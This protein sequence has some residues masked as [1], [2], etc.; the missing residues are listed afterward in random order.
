[1][2]NLRICFKYL[3]ACKEGLTDASDLYKGFS[4]ALDANAAL[5]D[6]LKQEGLCLLK[7]FQAVCKVRIVISV[8]FLLV[9]LSNQ[10]ILSA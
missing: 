9:D 8:A 2:G 7:R 10:K 5:A 6:S 3:Q 4:S 1:M